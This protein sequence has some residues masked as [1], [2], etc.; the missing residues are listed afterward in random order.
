MIEAITAVM[1]VTAYTAGFESTGKRPGDPGY[2]LTYCGLI[3]QQ[4]RT[5]AAGAAIPLGTKI[6]IPA[7]GSWPNGGIFT[8]EDR[9]GA[10]SNAHVDIYMDDLE[11][12]RRWGRQHLETLLWLEQGVSV[13]VDRAIESDRQTCWRDRAAFAK[14]AKVKP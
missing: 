3:A 9:G 11:A 14:W 6:F 13:Q 1:E 2:G 5:V 7:L 10:I 12:A 8:V 4:G